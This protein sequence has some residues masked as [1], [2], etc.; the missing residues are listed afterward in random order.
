MS[1]RRLG[2]VGCQ[3]TNL[4]VSA[5]EARRRPKR[6]FSRSLSVGRAR[7]SRGLAVP[8]PAQQERDHLVEVWP[9]LIGALHDQGGVTEPDN[10]GVD[11]SGRNHRVLDLELARARAVGNKT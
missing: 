11:A 10:G 4:R 8:E 9:R 1:T 6:M 3:A 7:L 2:P 5:L